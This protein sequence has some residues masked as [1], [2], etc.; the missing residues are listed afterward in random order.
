MLENQ[1]T[2]SPRAED[3]QL[4]TVKWDLSH[5]FNGKFEDPVTAVDSLL[6]EADDKAVAFARDYSGKVSSLDADGLLRAMRELELLYELVS[7]TGSYATL[8]FS[9]DT[10]DPKRGALLQKVQERS[11]TV[12]TK[13][14]F[15]D[16]EWAALDDSQ[17]ERVCQ[18]VRQ[19]S[20]QL[21]NARA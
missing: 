6:D 8:D 10:T 12:E 20:I 21:E 5:I 19:R 18:D 4:S 15:F 9:V 16:L 14:L 1:E 13:T 2:A 11:T 3:E 17:A 7:R